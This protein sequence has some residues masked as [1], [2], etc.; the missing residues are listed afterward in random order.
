MVVSPKIVQLIV[1][2]KYLVKAVDP[3]KD[4]IFCVVALNDN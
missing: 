4:V 3:K 1:G 2:G